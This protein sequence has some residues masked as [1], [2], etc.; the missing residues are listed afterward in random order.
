MKRKTIFLLIFLL[1][2]GISIAQNKKKPIP[3]DSGFTKISDSNLLYNYNPQNRRDPFYDL[4][5]GLKSRKKKFQKGIKPF[6][7]SEIQLT[8]IIGFKGSYNALVVTPEGV[9]YTLKDGDKL[10]DGQVIKVGS[11]FIKFRQTLKNPIMLKK[12]RDII[13]R[14]N[15]DENQ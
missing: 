11:D 1:I 2:A 6:Y 10:L 4:I 15:M 8:G 5:K 3:E 12:T 13:K 7:I 14:L 9:A